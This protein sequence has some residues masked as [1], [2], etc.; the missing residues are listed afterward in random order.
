M[1]ILP[2]DYEIVGRRKG[3]EDVILILQVRAGT[4]PPTV[5]VVCD[6]KLTR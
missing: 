3:Y 6:K 4:P 1:K 2:G 5:I